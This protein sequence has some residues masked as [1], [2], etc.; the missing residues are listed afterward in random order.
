MAPVFFL[1]YLPPALEE[2]SYAHMAKKVDRPVPPP[3]ARVY[4]ISFEHDGILWIAT[5]G[6]TLKGC[7]PVHR[8]CEEAE[9][10]VIEDT[11]LILAIFAGL[12]YCVITAGCANIP[13]HFANPFYADPKGIELFGLAE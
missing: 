2:A 1:P 13:S 12:P 8:N 4:A 7:A 6:E 11:A 3:G 5:V 9:M 10:Q